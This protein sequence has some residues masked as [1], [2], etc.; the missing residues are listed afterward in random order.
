MSETAIPILERVRQRHP[1]QMQNRSEND[2][3][4]IFVAKA[5]GVY[6]T[7]EDWYRGR[8]E[9]PLITRKHL[10]RLVQERI[11]CAE[12]E[13]LTTTASIIT[14]SRKRRAMSMAESEAETEAGK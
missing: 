11:E 12:S 5:N 13:N 7:P 3:T 10:I 14:K 8:K 9:K 6:Y 4:R 1:G 2:P